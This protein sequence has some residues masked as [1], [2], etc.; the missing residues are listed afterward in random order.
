MLFLKNRTITLNCES[1]W[2]NYI[3]EFEDDVNVLVQNAQSIMSTCLVQFPNREVVAMYKKRC[4]IIITKNGILSE[5][6]DLIMEESLV[7]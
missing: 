4:I 5:I 1:S 3:K 2:P 6:V 7:L